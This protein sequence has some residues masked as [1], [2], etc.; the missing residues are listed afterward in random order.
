MVSRKRGY[1]KPLF[2]RDTLLTVKQLKSR[3]QQS[4]SY[5]TQL[6]DTHHEVQRYQN[7]LAR[8]REIRKHLKAAPLLDYLSSSHG[9]VKTHY[10]SFKV[11]NGS[12]WINTGRRAITLVT[13]VLSIWD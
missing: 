8:F 2:V 1:R 3:A 4:E 10:S 9:L 11:K 5:V 7:E 13:F 6:L 12:V